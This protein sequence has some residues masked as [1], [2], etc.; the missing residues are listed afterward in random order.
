FWVFAWF[1]LVLMIFVCF[2]FILLSYGKW[3]IPLFVLLA[4]FSVPFSI[5]Y[6]YFQVG[7]PASKPNQFLR[8]AFFYTL[9][10]WYVSLLDFLLL[11]SLFPFFFVKP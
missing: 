4:C 1:V 8:I 5:N 10:K 11:T 2:F 3:F 6:S 9:K 7:N